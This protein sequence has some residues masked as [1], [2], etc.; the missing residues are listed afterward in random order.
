MKYLTI[1]ILFL[2][3]ILQAQTIRTED[4]IQF[5]SD[6]SKLGSAPPVFYYNQNLAAGLYGFRSKAATSSGNIFFG[7]W[8]GKYNTTGSNNTGSGINSF[9]AL[10]SGNLNTC[11]GSASL[12]NLIDGNYGTAYGAQ[13]GYSTVHGSGFVYIGFQAGYFETGSNKLYISNSW[14]PTPLIYGDFSNNTL[15]LGTH[16]N[17]K[18]DGSTSIPGGSTYQVNNVPINSMVRDSIRSNVAFGEHHLLVG[19]L[20]TITSPTILTTY[21]VTQYTATDVSKDVSSASN[22]GLQVTTSGMYLI[23]YNVRILQGNLNSIGISVNGTRNLDSEIDVFGSFFTGFAC[24]SKILY[25]NAADIVR[26]TVT[27]SSQTQVDISLKSAGL[28]ISKLIN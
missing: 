15:T 11:S 5:K 12:T 13:S 18:T 3:H 6:N 23:N 16:W 20:Q 8:S 17:L 24:G 27:T 10:Q 14:T 19:G 21:N 22:G 1:I 26:M 28:T 4:T 2:G 9:A 7:D 25:L